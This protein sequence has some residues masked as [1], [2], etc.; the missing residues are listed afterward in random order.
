M[1]ETGEIRMIELLQ[2]LILLASQLLE[3]EKDLE[4]ERKAKKNNTT[5][6]RKV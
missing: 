3:I 5:L 1:K 6:S 2:K 4:N